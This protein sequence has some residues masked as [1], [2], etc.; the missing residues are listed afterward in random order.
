[1]TAKVRKGKEQSHERDVPR[2]TGSGGSF[3]KAALVCAVATLIVAATPALAQLY[4]TADYA[5]LHEPND[6]VMGTD[7]GMGD[8][9]T[10]HFGFEG[11]Y[12]GAYTNAPF[13]GAYFVGTFYL[14]LWRT[15]FEAFAD[16]GGLVVSGELPN[17][18]GYT[19]WSSGFRADAGLI[20][21]LTP[22]WGIR[23]AYRYQT[24]LARMTAETIGLT[25]SF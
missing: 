25:F 11:G 21:D 15:G 13:S 8:R 24:P 20:Y 14:P 1:L 22:T 2:K 5:N 3:M 12:E 18:G 4:V 16:A 9:L 6:T 10:Q 17:T 7:V 19:R 23:A